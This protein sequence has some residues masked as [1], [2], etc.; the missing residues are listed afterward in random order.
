MNLLKIIEKEA[1]Y[2][3]DTKRL[4]RPRRVCVCS[5]A[6]DQWKGTDC[7]V[8]VWCDDY[9]SGWCKH[10]FKGVPEGEPLI[11]VSKVKELLDEAAA[12]YPTCVGCRWLLSSSDICSMPR[13]LSNIIPRKN[14]EPDDDACPKDKWFFDKF[15]GLTASSSVKDSSREKKGSEEKWK[16]GGPCPFCGSNDVGELDATGRLYCVTCGK[17]E[18][19]EA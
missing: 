2:V 7:E 13:I 14:P 19:E 16:F 4:D 11:P 15:D 3:E 17:S 10:S 1:F 8:Y 6:C 12:S 18:K 9:C 5:T